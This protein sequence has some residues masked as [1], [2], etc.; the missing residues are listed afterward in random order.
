[1]EKRQKAF[2][3]IEVLIAITVLI[4]GIL[5]GFILVTKALYN[6]AVIKDRLTASFLAQE[7]IELTRQI[8]DS[9]F[10]RILDS[11]EESA[12][13]RDG[14]GDGTYIIESKVDS[15]ESIRLVPIEEDQNRFLFYDNVLK[16]YNYDDNGEPTSFNRKIKITTIS[17]DEIR[18]ESIMQWKTRTIDFDLFVEDHL[19]NWM[20]L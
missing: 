8:R 16:I 12:D 18:V 20:K 9:N 19:Y 11:E 10:L 3:L 13:W 2:T 7:G 17:D 5:S 14:L 1:M 6:V 4:I 15:E